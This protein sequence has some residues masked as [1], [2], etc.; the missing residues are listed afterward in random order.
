MDNTRPP[1]ET[2]GDD[3][4]ASI[5]VESP[6]IVEEDLEDAPEVA[7]EDDEDYDDHVNDV[8]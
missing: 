1:E 5:G 7:P 2:E 3:Q 4:K 6:S 8:T